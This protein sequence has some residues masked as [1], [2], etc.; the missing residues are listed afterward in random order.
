VILLDPIIQ[1]LALPDTDRLRMNISPFLKPAGH[2]AGND[3]FS[4]RLTTVNHN[5]LWTPMLFKCLCEKP[6]GCGQVPILAKPEING[7]SDAVD[8]PIKIHPLT[9]YLDVSLVC[10]PFAGH[11]TFPAIEAVQNQR[12]E[13]YDPPMDRRMIYADA[14]FEH[15]FLQV[16]KAQAVG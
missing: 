2:I 4:V 14:S 9:P 12:R 5:A 1:V 11:R 3:G 7:V 13:V 15:H 8:G 10:M 16:A 6:L